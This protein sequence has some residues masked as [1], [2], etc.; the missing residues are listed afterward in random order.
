MPLEPTERWHDEIPGTRWF[1]ADLHLHTLDD[2]YIA[3]PPGIEGER[4]DPAVLKAYA[5]HFLDAAVAQGIEVLGLTPHAPS[6]KAGLSAA[7]TIITTW[8]SGY[9]PSSGRAYRDLIYAVYP[10]FEP[11]FADGNNG[12]HLIFLFDPTVGKEQYLNAFSAIMAGRP[13]YEG[14]N[15][16]QTLKA[17]KEVFAELDDRLSIGKG[18]YLVIAAHPLQ[19]N[20][21]L[22]R[23]G[24]YITDLAGGHIHAAELRRNRTLS[25]DLGDNS[26]LRHAF[27][28]GRVAL[29]HSSDAIKLA[30]PNIAPTDQ[31]L[32]YRFAL[33]KLASPSLEA[34]KQAFLGRDSRLRIPYIRDAAGQFV[35]DPHLPVPVPQGHDARPWIREIRVLGGASFLRDQI[36]RFSPD[37]TGIIGGSMTGKS[38]LLDGLRLIFGGEQAMPNRATSLGQNALARAQNRFLSGGTQV[39][40]E[41]PAGD[42]ARPVAERFAPRFFSQGELKSLAEDDEGIEHLLFHLIPGRGGALLAQRDTLNSIDQRI[43]KAVPRLTRLQAQVAEAEQELQRTAEAREAMK[44]F[45]QAGT[46]ALPPAQQDAARAKTFASDA[47][48][49]IERALEMSEALGTLSLPVFNS[50][51]IRA[52]LSPPEPAD[53]ADAA[54][55]LNKAK[56]QAEAVFTALKSIGEMANAT[57]A[58]ANTRLAQ[59]TAQVQAALV[60]TGRSASD[61]N[62]FEAYA[63]TAQHH[64]SFLAALQGKTL[65]F[66]KAFKG[67]QAD[68]V[69][70]DALIKTHRTEVEQICRE[71]ETRFAGRVVVAV[72]PEGRRGP[73]ESWMLGLRNPGIS[74]WWNSGGS[75]SATPTKLRAV[76]G[77]FTKQDLEQ[78]QTQAKA[79]G[80]S[81]A[82]ATSFLEQIAPWARQLE[83]WALRSPD[84]YRIRWVED[85][86]PKD[87]DDLSGGRRVAVLLSLIL[88]SDDPTPLFVDQPEDELDNRF[89]NET[90]IPALHRLKGKRQVVFATHNANLVVNGDAD[91]VIALEADAQHGRVYA[92]GAIENDA[93]R[94]A[95]V[96]T[97][98]GGD[99]A[100]GLRRKKYGF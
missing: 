42:L 36:F 50:P 25:E 38:T 26:K 91:Q 82:V 24:H 23:P 87:L 98:D 99:D 57:E 34:L 13:G 4:D 33:L 6:I 77:A 53:T 3:L 19:Q 100:F 15:L 76:I 45:E 90:I 51:E 46:P 28:K 30:D 79:L 73:L 20:G 32:G 85:G 72:D 10:G 56:A 89:L 75:Q 66:E 37:L 92:A 54:S 71:V 78:A 40:M 9:Q 63:K 59:M 86:T 60:A 16:H 74:R 29:Y 64:D 41:S 61:L 27:E 93:V 31:A 18:N 81:D 55:L 17:P 48:D 8:E 68:L 14:K 2:P 5:E 12:I 70:R 49:Q 1:R 80:M 43:A 7:W 94:T 65:E 67:F 62:Q 52:S 58:A 21:L 95:I 69:E 47:K 39:E 88:E 84:R 97:L 83:V 35:Q 22:S 11:S 96:R 44:Q